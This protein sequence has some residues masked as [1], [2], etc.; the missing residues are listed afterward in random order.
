MSA[1]TEPAAQT[2][3]GENGRADIVPAPVVL[4]VDPT[5]TLAVKDWDDAY[6]ELVK[7]TVLKPKNREA[8]KVE[9]YFFAEQIKRTGLDPFHRQI[10]AIYRKKKGIEELTI[11]V[12]IDGFRLIAE[13]TGKYEGQTEQQWC[14]PDGVWHTVWA[15]EGHPFAAR[16]GVYKKGRREPT[17][18]VAHW[19]EYVQ[20]YDGTP[21]GK[22]MPTSKGGMP[23]NQLSK[24]AEALA[25]RK[26][27][28][29][30]L[31]GLYTPEEMEQADR[32]GLGDGRGSGEPAG[33]VLGDA[34]EAVLARAAR[35]GH[36]AIADRGMVEMRV[37]DEH[38]NVI[39]ERAAKWIAEATAELDAMPQDAVVVEADPG[40]LRRD[41]VKVGEDKGEA[42]NAAQE[43]VAA[44][45]TSGSPP[46]VD[47]D[48]LAAMKRRVDELLNDVDALD[49]MDPRRAQEC[50]DEA[51]DLIT[52]IESAGNPEQGTM[53]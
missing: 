53:L 9:L 40:D 13:R 52:A 37:G 2:M 35:L 51:E 41:T 8:T 45:E 44:S 49:D 23:A 42:D 26:C 38:G 46:V 10:Y 17:Y 14:G 21:T 16:C 18:A 6:R 24:C 39:A 5:T 32:E 33:L 48:R 47:A 34:I 15:Q 3:P 30:E 36:H 4:D 29:A 31:S 12:G 43:P 20:T 28:P 19:A 22:W 7:R 50:R 27:F 25:L 11:Q 1:T